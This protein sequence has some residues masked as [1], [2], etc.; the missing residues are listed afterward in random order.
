M[1]VR[2]MLVTLAAGAVLLYP[3]ALARTQDSDQINRLL[4][5]AKTQAYEL[6]VDAFRMETF[7][8]SPSHWQNHLVVVEHMKEHVNAA[9]KTLAKLEEVRG[10]A[11]PW[12][13][14]A[15]DRIKPVLKEIAANT[16]AVINYLNKHPKRLHTAEYKDYLEA[17]ADYSSKLAELVANFVDYGNAK[18]RLDRLTAKLELPAN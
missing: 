9:G 10:T 3:S 2:T 15:I 14:I 6:S 18:D 8:R 11:S 1:K 17:N 13:A 16:T 12:Q 4:A 7:T 5:D